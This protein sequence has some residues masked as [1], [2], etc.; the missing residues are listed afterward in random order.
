[1]EQSVGG[2][3]AIISSEQVATLTQ[4]RIEELLAE[5]QS[6]KE[7]VSAQYALA[8]Q[9]PHASPEMDLLT[10]HTRDLN[11]RLVNCED[12]L[13]NLHAAAHDATLTKAAAGGSG[14]GGVPSPTPLLYKADSIED[15]L[16]TV[17]SLDRNSPP[18]T[19]P[20][21]L[22]GVVD[23]SLEGLDAAGADTDR[24][25]DTL[26][27]AHRTPR[28]GAP[29]QEAAD[30]S[31]GAVLHRRASARRSSARDSL[32]STPFMSSR[33]SSIAPN[34]SLAAQLIGEMC[35]LQDALTKS[36]AAAGSLAP[37]SHDPTLLHSQLEQLR[38]LEQELDTKRALAQNLDLE[39]KKLAGDQ[40]L[41]RK[42]LEEVKKANHNLKQAVKALSS[43]IHQANSGLTLT[44]DAAAEFSELQ[45]TTASTMDTI[46]A[47][48]PNIAQLN[49][50]PEAAGGLAKV[51]ALR[52][53]LQ[54]QGDALQTMRKLSRTLETQLS[55]NS[56]LSADE[57]AAPLRAVEQLEVRAAVLGTQLQSEAARLG[58]IQATRENFSSGLR[59]A[60]NE[61]D[62]VG[63]ALMAMGPLS[64]RPERISSQLEERRVLDNSLKQISS[65]LATM[66]A[67]MI[68]QSVTQ[69][70]LEAF[71]A[72]Y[73]AHEKRSQPLQAHNRQ[74]MQRA[75]DTLPAAEIF[76]EQL[77]KL[78]TDTERVKEALERD[79]GLALLMPTDAHLLTR[80]REE[81][82]SLREDADALQ[83]DLEACENNGKRLQETLDDPA[84]RQ[85]I[86]SQLESARARLEQSNRLLDARTHVFNEQTTGLDTF[87]S[88]LVALRDLIEAKRAE[89]EH[90]FGA[91]GPEVMGRKSL[92]ELRE[93]LEQLK[94]FKG[95]LE[96]Q[97]KEL[98]ELTAIEER[99]KSQSMPESREAIEQ[100]AGQVRDSWA[101]LVGRVADHKHQLQNVLVGRG[102]FEHTF[103]DLTEWM[104]ATERELAL[105]SVEK[106]LGD[107]GQLELLEHKLKVLALLLIT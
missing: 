60:G 94:A 65:R 72:E 57:R 19:S 104:N 35:A 80:L 70:E 32:S 75:Q 98:L 63:N 59:T 79:E 27:S 54:S 47:E 8:E 9:L 38:A 7:R 101:A 28:L 36:T 103:D 102:D 62:D 13:H 25:P 12:E 11:R 15:D 50:G 92:E 55:T 67:E 14:S 97:D 86:S 46:A 18:L 90:Y 21:A 31:A 106:Y 77:T 51:G 66:R 39:Y 45:Q 17:D 5:V 71:A 53:D 100:S 105:L 29:G 26:P 81:L 22:L 93:R 24:V 3:E 89:F 76:W 42:A 96:A 83:A 58:G 73:D 82:D 99:L 68:A 52:D 88:R 16:A 6:D 33:P 43:A 74:E 49:G 107:T 69:P 34:D 78:Q 91:E 41:S 56:A 40:L 85:Q 84:E 1:M 37:Q 48:L 30:S 20:R 44:L 61:L 87:S 2:L 4:A 95:E 23:E 10:E 64:C